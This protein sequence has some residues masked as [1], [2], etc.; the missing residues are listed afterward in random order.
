MGQAKSR[1]NQAQRMAQALERAST[2]LP[3]SVKCETCQ[4]EMTQITP[5]DVRDMPGINLAGVA[6]CHACGRAA[7]ALRGTPHAVDFHLNR[8]EHAYAASRRAT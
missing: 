1:G 5:M 3:A 7:W 2:Q 8:L 6:H 4:V